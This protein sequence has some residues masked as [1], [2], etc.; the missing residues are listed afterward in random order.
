MHRQDTIHSG[1]RAGRQGIKTILYQP[2]IIC[3][4][5]LGSQKTYTFI[6]QSRRKAF[7]PLR[8]HLASQVMKIRK[9]DQRMNIEHIFQQT[10]L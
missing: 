6:P 5:V 9:N 8:D 7:T 1:D 2:K 10:N 3:V 4:C